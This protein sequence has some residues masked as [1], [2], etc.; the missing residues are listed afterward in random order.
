MKNK[1]WLWITLTTLL[2]IVVLF[3]VAGAGFRMGIMQ[4]ANLIKNADGTTSPFPPFGH[5]RGFEGNFNNQ[6]GGDPHMMQGF[7]HG[8]GSEHGGFDRGGHG[9]FFTPLF[10]LFHLT[11]AGLLLWF[12]YKFVKNSGWRITRV[13][14]PVPSSE[15]NETPIVVTEE[16]K[17]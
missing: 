11:A 6:A 4:S 15:E 17:E 10:G 8:G 3:G 12:G 13:T 14:Q 5:M 9:R 16:K 2:T 1:K 7:R